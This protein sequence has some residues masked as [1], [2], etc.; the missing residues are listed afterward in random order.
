ME[1][2]INLFG[3]P[4][5]PSVQLGTTIK[6]VEDFYGDGPLMAFLVSIPHCIFNSI[7]AVAEKEGLKLKCRVRARYVLDEKFLKTGIY[8]F[9]KI[10]LEVSSQDCDE[11][12]LRDLVAKVKMECP[13][14]LSFMDRMEIQVLKGE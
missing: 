12:D 8:R 11:E 4:D 10:I 14:Y 2:T 6:P 3:S 13:I 7:Y 5:S 1:I 9:T